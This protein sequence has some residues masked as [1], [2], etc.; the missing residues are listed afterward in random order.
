MYLS[1][2]IKYPSLLYDCNQNRY[3]STNYNLRHKISLNLSGVSRVL[4]GTDRQT[5]RSWYLFFAASRK[6]PKLDSILVGNAVQVRAQT[7]EMCCFKP[8]DVRT[9]DF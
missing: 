7:N 1:L 2:H 6:R 4:N 3:G 9:T 8:L 5:R